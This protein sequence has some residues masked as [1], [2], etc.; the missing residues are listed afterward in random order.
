MS[1]TACL[2]KWKL[3]NE[4][5]SITRRPLSVILICKNAGTTLA[6]TLE[7]IAPYA[8]Q[9]VA[10]INNCTDNTRDVLESYQA[11]IIE[12]PWAGM[13]AQKTRLL[14]MLLSPGF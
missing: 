8:S 11:T 3:K 6:R 4:K 14:S 5:C 9:I 13:T 1:Y 10:V 7:P 12:Q 2:N